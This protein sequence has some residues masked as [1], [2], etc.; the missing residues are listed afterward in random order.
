MKRIRSTRALQRTAAG[1]AA[2]CAMARGAATS[3]SHPSRT[4]ARRGASKRSSSRAASRAALR[5]A[6]RTTAF[7]AHS[8][9]PRRRAFLPP[10]PAPVLVYAAVRTREFKGHLASHSTRARSV[11]MCLQL[12]VG[13]HWFVFHERVQKIF[14]ES[15]GI[16]TNDVSMLVFNFSHNLHFE[17]L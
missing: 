14:R 4:R 11:L 1:G 2:R 13:V 17:L 3:S 15:I 6:Q 9:A 10:A 16:H 8:A 7:T 5:C 12:H